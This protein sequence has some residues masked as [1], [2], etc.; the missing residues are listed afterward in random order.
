MARKISTVTIAT[1]G[2]DRGKIFHLKEMSAHQTATWITRALLLLTH[3]GVDIPSTRDPEQLMRAAYAAL[4]Q[5]KYE[6]LMPLLSELMRCVTIQ[7]DPRH[8]N[9]IRPILDMGDDSDD[10]EEYGT[11][12]QLL[13]EIFKLHTGI[14]IEGVMPGMVG[15]AASQSSEDPR[16][17]AKPR[18][19]GPAPG[20][21]R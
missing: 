5:V 17:R 15:G 12:F 19:R 9:V 21:R 11:R 1:E 7:P 20:V 18:P 2:R 14:S 10:I 8:P 13:W 16:P 3:S 6:E 4:M